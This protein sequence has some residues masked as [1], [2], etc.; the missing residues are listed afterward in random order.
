MSFPGVRKRVTITVTDET[1]DP[2]V[3][4]DPGELEVEYG[5]VG[6]TPTTKTWPADD[7]IENDS[8]GVF[9][10]DIDCPTDGLWAVRAAATSGVIG[11]DEETWFVKA[12][13]FPEPES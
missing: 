7:E 10:I 13:H 9:H 1:L 5:P 2:P 11:V 8:T 12:S 6:E 4:S 3:L